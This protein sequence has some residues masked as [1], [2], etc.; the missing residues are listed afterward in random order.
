MRSLLRL[1]AAAFVAAAPGVLGLGSTDSYRDADTMQSGYLP[2]HNMDPAVVSGPTF[3]QLWRISGTGEY[4]GQNEQF[5]SKPLVYTPS[6]GTYAG[7]QIVLAFSQTNWVYVLNSLDGTIMNSRQLARPFLVSD[8]GCNDISGTIGITSTPVIDP[9]TDTV[10]LYA[11]SYPGPDNGYVNGAYY[12]HA[13]DVSTLVERPG[14]PVNPGGYPADNDPTRYFHGGTHLQRPSLALI[15]NV[16][17]AGFGGH[18]DLFNF[19]G[20]LVG[21]DTSGKVKTLFSTEVAPFAPKQDGTFNGGGGGA[22]IWQAG[23]GLST[24][25]PNRLFF[26]TGNGA[27]HEN[28]QTPASG[29]SPLSTLDEAIVNVKID[30]ATGKLSLSDY[31]EPYE[32]ISMDAADRDL[33]SGGAALLDPAAFSGNNAARVGV[34]VGK[35]GKAYIFNADNLGGF[36]NGPGGGDAVLQ[37]LNMPNGG[38]IFGGAGSYPLEGGYI[39]MTPVGYPTQVYSFGKDSAGNVQFT[40]VAQ[41]LENSAG[42]VGVGVPTITTL[43]GQAG[44]AIL[45]ITDVDNGLRAYHAVP[46]NG[47]MVKINMPP[48]P[49]LTKYQRPAF[50][51]GRLYLSTSDGHIIC[52]GSPVNLPFTCNTPLDFGE[53]A[54]GSNKTLNVTCQANIPITQVQGILSSSLRFTVKNSS[55]PTGA[56]AKGANITFPVTF[57]LSGAA[58]SDNTNTSVPSVSPGLLSAA[59]TLLTN[60]GIP[61]FT[62]QQP[63]A[64]SGTTVSKNPFLNIQPPQ[65][66]FGGLVKGSAEA[67]A[68]KAGSIK[69]QN[70]GLGNLTITGLAYFDTNGGDDDDGVQ[71]KNVTAG[72]NGTFVVGTGFTAQLLPET[73]DVIPAGGSVSVGLV[74]KTPNL[75]QYGSVLRIY[76]NGGTQQVLFS[77]AISDAPEALLEISTSEGGWVQT[78][79]VDFGS[80]AAGKQVTRKIRITNVG[81]SGLTITKSKPP[82]GAELGAVNPTGDLS[83][84]LLIAPG[85]SAIGPVLFAP[86]PRP[87]NQAPIPVNGTW[88]LNTDDL[89][90][91]VHVIFFHG[92]AT[93]TQRGPLLPDGT[94]RFKYLGCWQDAQ[95]GKGRL[96]PSLKNN[97]ANNTNDLC[98]KQAL[99]DGYIFAGTQ[100]HVECWRGNTPPDMQW[101]H[102]ESERKCT[103]TCSGDT[104]QTCG[105]DGKYESIYYDSL[106]YSPSN[107]SLPSTTSSSSISSSTS[108]AT[109]SAS[110]NS[111]SGSSTPI[112]PST[113]T[114]ASSSASA[115]PTGPVIPL[116]VGSFSF[117]NCQTELTA[118]G[119]ALTG[120]RLANDSMTNELCAT[121]CGSFKFF[122]T[123][124]GRE[125]YCGDTVQAASTVVP[126][127]DCNKPCAANKL[128]Y[129]GAGSRL[130]LYSVSPT[131]SSS[132]SSTASSTS[133]SSS[134]TSS[135]ISSSSSASSSTSSSSSSVSSSVS[136][137]SAQPS[138]T[139]P[140]INPGNV[141]FAYQSCLLEPDTGRALGKNVVSNN[142][143]TVQICLDTCPQYQY[144]GLE[145]GRECWCGNAILN[146][147]QVASSDSACNKV[148]KGNSTEYCGNGGALSLYKRKQTAQP[149]RRRGMKKTLERWAAA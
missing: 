77:G 60:N 43:K 40:L 59:I 11:K 134:S 132:A 102:A 61:K 139:G 131:T 133:S 125:C 92:L 37:T 79:D 74:F 13:L 22:G 47:K 94:S 84:G 52:L 105:G 38:S 18:C 78:S 2:N 143:M 29:R 48:T 70:V 148:C 122:A 50:G 53:V 119:R 149:K 103:W 97:G 115:S 146:N 87:D 41:T 36:K 83:E 98:Q 42:R 72:T 136:S 62:T 57:D 89:T 120:K 113:S 14:F 1:L 9:A 46:Q 104:N 3:G 140:V 118:G 69:I 25:S 68:G 20:W 106:R 96:L 58:I 135:I 71:L 32:Y 19:T 15:N 127:S 5:Y 145:Y 81:G 123:E 101:Y 67:Q 10:Y 30:T 121:F 23:M 100:Y 130:Q 27:G 117:V 90:F 86:I 76:S 99:A 6:T 45:W 34:T 44:T 64:V 56:V 4:N 39:Y 16:V 142:S 126:K 63:L 80:L 82:E 65:V 112:N 54:I 147:A 138:P 24:D 128:Q 31:F 137:S 109:S 93:T 124:Y 7:K 85:E 51:D 35:N 8:I 88:T 144:A 21:I 26:V 49:A 114:S 12:L 73:G 95:S 28:K 17:Y 91:G 33:G 75:G 111:T 116:T 110:A 107:S 129:C 108:S 55:L 141:N 66:D